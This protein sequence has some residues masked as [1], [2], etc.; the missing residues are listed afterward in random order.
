MTSE[1]P[2]ILAL[3]GATSTFCFA[4]LDLAF[5]RPILTGRAGRLGN[6]AAFVR[7]EVDGQCSTAR[8]PGADHTKALAGLRAF[9]EGRDLVR[10]I[11]TVGH[12]VAGVAGLGAD[13]ILVTP[14]VLHHLAA[15]VGP[16]SHRARDRLAGLAAALVVLPEAR[17]VAVFQTGG[18]ARIAAT[19]DTQSLRSIG[20]RAALC[21]I[22]AECEKAP[23]RP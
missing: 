17:H 18:P 11:G 12:R 22:A 3:N 15:T 7:I 19:G 13:A 6:D 5:P 8:L 4:L 10:R 9:L 14:E 16:R 20:L 2:L 1:P 21:G 23:P